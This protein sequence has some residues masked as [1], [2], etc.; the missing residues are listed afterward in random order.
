MKKEKKDKD[1]IKS[2]YFEGGRSAIDAFIKQELR[3]PKE[4]LQG[5]IEGTVS[6]QYT[7]DFK[8]NVIEAKVI[9][10]IGHGCDEEAIR[11]VKL[12]KFKVPEDGKVKSKYSNKLHIHFRLPGSSAKKAAVKKA[13]IPANNI[14]YQYVVTPTPQSTATRTAPSKSS[15]EFNIQIGSKK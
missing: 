14:Q 11:V 12:M 5:K 2:A 1:F 8:G 15:Y 4:A 13:V 7:V 10:G 6:V 3:Y 9:S